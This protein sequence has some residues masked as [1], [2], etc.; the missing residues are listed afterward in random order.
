M[1]NVHIHWPLLLLKAIHRNV[2]IRH[3]GSEE[4]DNRVIGVQ[5]ES[6]GLPLTELL[7]QDRIYKMFKIFH[8]SEAN[9]SLQQL[10]AAITITLARTPFSEG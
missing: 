3:V 2:M 9:N 7:S 10:Q 6:N 4:T 5:K 1:R 8:L